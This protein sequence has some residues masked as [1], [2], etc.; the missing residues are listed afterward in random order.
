MF[1]D[2]LSLQLFIRTVEAGSLSKAAEQSHMA[3][4]AVSRRIALLEQMYDTRL[5]YRTSQGVEVTPAG[6]S[7]LRH[8][9]MLLEQSGRLRADLADFARGVRSHVRVQAATS[10]ITQHLPKDLATFASLCPDVKVE[11]EEKR[12]AAVVQGVKEGLADIGIVMQDIPMDGLQ[13]FEYRRDRLVALVPE[14]H[15][16]RKRQVRFAELLDHDFIGLD[17][18]AAMTRLLTRIAASSGQTLRLRMQVHSFEAVC[19]LVSAGMGIGVLPE[20][21]AT[22]AAAAMAL[23]IIQL[24][25]DWAVRRMYACV[26]DV[27]ELSIIAR[28]LLTLLIGDQATRV[29]DGN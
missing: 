29:Q 27:E 28:K 15:P 6:Q 17:S 23:R 3:L 8:A 24:T 12:S 20:I 19:E 25:D 1:P 5:L 10:V 11:L 2:L 21:P 26:R 7:L 13:S 4:A 14:D 16:V 18:S 9:R 22:K